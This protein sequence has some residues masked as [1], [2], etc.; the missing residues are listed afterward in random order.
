MKPQ[1]LKKALITLLAALLVGAAVYGLARLLGRTASDAEMF[2]LIAVAVGLL[3]KPVQWI[4]R[5][6][7]VVKK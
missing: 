6:L 1:S 2:G 7:G 5:H 4:L 3:E